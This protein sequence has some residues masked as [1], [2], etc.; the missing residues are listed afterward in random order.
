MTKISLALI[1]IL[2]LAFT[3]CSH[4]GSHIKSRTINQATNA[5]PTILYSWSQYIGNDEISFRAIVDST[6]C[7][8]ITRD[9]ELAQMLLRS[10]LFSGSNLR[11]CEY[12][13]GQNTQSAKIGATFLPVAASELKRIAAFGDTGCRMK[14]AGPFKLIQ[15][16]NNTS[17]W[18]F[19]KIVNL[20]AGKKPDLAI[21]LGD[22]NYRDIDCP[23]NNPKCAGQSAKN[24]WLSWE[25]D[26]IKPM[27]ALLKLTPF[28][29]VRGNHENCGMFGATWFKLFASEV[30]DRNEKCDEATATFNVKIDNIDFVNIDASSENNQKN[31]ITKLE[32]RFSS[33]YLWLLTHRPFLA[34]S[35]DVNI[36]KSAKFNKTMQAQGAVQLV[37][38][39]HTHI[40]S[41]V[42]FNNNNPPELIAGHGGVYIDFLSTGPIPT[43][44]NNVYTTRE[45]GFAYFEKIDSASWH[46][47]MLNKNGKTRI[48]C[49][50]LQSV[51]AKTDVTCKY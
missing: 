39:G 27:S 30:Y 14:K 24:T 17:D 47:N 28:I 16:C 10:E 5:E 38:A 11:V 22:Y 37:M 32:K 29:F 46:L 34:A 6:E 42:S 8:T 1:T 49:K 7:P 15:N 25:Q 43:E 51:S 23:S 36:Y 12:R 2:T 26:V 3:S 18:P 48:K 31:E 9:E 13:G 40:G 20:A 41:I 21:H 4:M 50:L 35:R 19:E 45:Y 44:E 33:D